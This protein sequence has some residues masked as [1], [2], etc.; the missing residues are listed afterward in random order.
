M[1]MRVW[2][3]NGFRTAPL[4]ARKLFEGHGQQQQQQVQA[5]Q[6]QQQ[7]QQQ[8]AEQQ[9]EGKESGNAQQ[10]Q[11]Q[12]QQQQLREEGKEVAHA[13]TRKAPDIADLPPKF[14][15]LHEPAT[16]SLRFSH[17]LAR[18]GACSALHC[19]WNMAAK[20][21]TPALHAHGQQVPSSRHMPVLSSS[22]NASVTSQ[23]NASV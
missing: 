22:Q 20:V 15:L 7:Q 1:R 19:M 18:L 8:H 9:I 17:A 21:G 10:Q 16:M 14:T 12:Q 13:D 2:E 3:V 4:R 23:G 5:Q 11:Q 6:Q